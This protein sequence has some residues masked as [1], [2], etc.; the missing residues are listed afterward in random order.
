MPRFLTIS[1]SFLGVE[2]IQE[3]LNFSVK[4]YI[5]I[6]RGEKNVNNKPISV[7]N[8]L[9]QWLSM[10]LCT[11]EVDTM[12]CTWH[13]AMLSFCITLRV[14]G[15]VGGTYGG[16]PTTSRGGAPNYVFGIEIWTLKIFA[17]GEIDEYWSFLNPLNSS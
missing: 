9:R 5:D 13:T 15:V 2:K 8:L 14:V 17:I 12:L 16:P 10:Q 11:I 1:N 6:Q 7:E 4:Y 3:I